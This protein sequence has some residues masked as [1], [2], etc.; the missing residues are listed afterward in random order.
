MIIRWLFELFN[1][2]LQTY[3]KW[4]AHVAFAR[5]FCLK[6]PVVRP[7]RPA[8][9][10]SDLLDSSLKSV[11]RAFR[12]SSHPTVWT[13]LTAAWE[14]TFGEQQLSNERHSRMRFLTK[15]GIGASRLAA[16]SAQEARAGQHLRSTRAKAA[17]PPQAIG[18]HLPVECLTRKLLLVALPPLRFDVGS[19]NHSNTRMQT[20]H[21]SFCIWN[22]RIVRSACFPFYFILVDKISCWQDCAISF[23]LTRLCNEMFWKD[24][25]CGQRSIRKQDNWSWSR[26]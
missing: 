3:A 23:L 11:P 2:Y 9:V 24:W 7:A 1:Q 10:I 8:K 12:C 21:Y 4:T 26:L 15:S 5:L 25:V 20:R 19:E 16:S 14:A 13:E 17:K 18:A 22:S 6:I